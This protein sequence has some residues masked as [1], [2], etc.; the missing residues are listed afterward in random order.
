[1]NDYQKP[2]QSWPGLAA[3]ARTV[4]LAKSGLTLHVYDTSGDAPPL[5]L[6]HGLA[7]EADTWRHVVTPLSAHYRV[8]APRPD[9]IRR[10]PGSA[11]SLVPEYSDL[12]HDKTV[13]SNLTDL[14]RQ[15][16]G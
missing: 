2:M 5:L 4:R 10:R 3:Y 15:Y 16:L 8:V 6:I 1:M 11:S 9:T 7:D 12:P 13:P 14:S